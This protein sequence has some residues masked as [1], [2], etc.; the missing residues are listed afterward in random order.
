MQAQRNSWLKHNTPQ[1][2]E[3]ECNGIIYT[4]RGG[5]FINNKITVKT[6]SCGSQCI[7]YL[8]DG[9]NEEPYWQERV[10][11]VNKVFGPYIRS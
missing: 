9:V 2:K 10:N 6:Y 7:S 1:Y 11:R 5:S 8:D 4:I 3:L